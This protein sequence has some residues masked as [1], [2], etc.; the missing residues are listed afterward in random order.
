MLGEW[1]IVGDC[2]VETRMQPRRRCLVDSKTEKACGRN[3]E[4]KMFECDRKKK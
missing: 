1:R 4:E 3:C 2:D